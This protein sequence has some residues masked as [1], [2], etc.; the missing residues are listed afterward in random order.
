MDAP[1]HH[2]GPRPGAQDGFTLIEVIVA[3]MLMSVVLMMAGGF[4][5]RSL[6]T[7]S[8]QSGRDGAVS[9]ANETLEGIRAVAATFDASGTSPLVYGRSLLEVTTQ[10]ADAAAA[11]LDVSKTH[12]GGGGTSFDAAT[13]QLVPSATETVPLR[14]TV[15][16]NYQAYTVDALIGTC[17]RATAAA[18]CLRTTSGDKLFR[19]VVRVTWSPGGGRTCSGPCE[20]VLS[21]IIDPTANPIFNSSR[22]PVANDDAATVVSGSPVDIGV[23]VN[24]SGDFALSGAVSLQTTPTNGTSSLTNN[25]VR[26]TPTLGFSGTTTFSYTVTD[27]GGRTSL[28][29][30][31]TVTVVPLAVNDT[32]PSVAVASG[33]VIVDV[34]A[35]DRGTSLSLVSAGTPSIGTA[36]INANRISYTPP[37]AASGPVTVVYT[38][39]DAAGSQY[40]ATLSLTV[41]PAPA[42]TG[43]A[44][45]C[46]PG[47]ATNAAAQT[48]NLTPGAAAFAGTGPFTLTNPVAVSPAGVTV[49]A[50]ASTFTYT[51]PASATLPQTFTY[52]V[53]DA[54]GVLSATIT[55]TVKAT[56]P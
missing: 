28:Y 18:E 36:T 24:D 14:R 26:Y 31:V 27:T 45:I 44:A 30:S 5:I 9:V 20:Y 37:V 54:S 21:T 1:A 49:S 23:T 38:G 40:T 51:L 17:G 6:A 15:S 22:R 19:V 11:G 48:K 47:W 35:N 46:W 25:I 10:W 16:R 34:L 52:A 56:C 43:T 42:T 33:A 12:T 29:A 4:M 53:G 8:V 39:R 13:Y 55:M 3:L 41:R 2:A 50:T 7:S 32:G